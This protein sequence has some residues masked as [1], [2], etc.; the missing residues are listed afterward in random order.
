MNAVALPRARSPLRFA[1]WGLRVATLAWAG[2][3]TWFVVVDGLGDAA[4]LGPS[5]YGYMLAFLV[6][7][8]LPTALAWRRPRLGA[9]TMAVFGVLTLV[10]FAN[11]FARAFFAGPP[12]VFAL[13]LAWLE[14]RER[15]R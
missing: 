10:Y 15:A 11:P 12:L 3:W 2:F 9:L 13:A 14:H 8:W 1:R 4:E 7:L 5:T 6:A